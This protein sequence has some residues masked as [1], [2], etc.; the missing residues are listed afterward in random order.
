MGILH[1]ALHRLAL[2]FNAALPH[3]HRRITWPHPCP[4]AGGDPRTT[5]QSTLR[6]PLPYLHSP[7][8]PSARRTHRRTIALLMLTCL[9]LASSSVESMNPDPEPVHAGPIQVFIMAGLLACQMVGAASH[10]QGSAC[11]WLR[12]VMRVRARVEPPAPHGPQCVCGHK[13]PLHSARLWTPRPVQHGGIRPRRR[14]QKVPSV[15]YPLF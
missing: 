8:T 15:A 13:I 3:K 10:Q 1:Q 2:G 12:S 14:V 5:A 11:F 7:N 6:R 4:P 9:G